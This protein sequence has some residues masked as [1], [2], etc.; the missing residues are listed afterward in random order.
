MGCT[1]AV[2]FAVW[3]QGKSLAES[4]EERKMRL[5]RE[6]SKDVDLQNPAVVND[7]ILNG[8]W[9]KGTR[10][11]AVYAYAD[12]CAFLGMPYTPLKIYREEKLPY[13]PLESRVDQLV[14][15]LSKTYAFFTR[16]RIE[17]GAALLNHFKGVLQR[18]PP[19]EASLRARRR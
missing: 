19:G 3:L 1:H 5:I 2:S 18:T 4:T 6:L 14:D 7:Y 13:V 8:S 16:D 12:Y 10:Q 11:L 9:S 15:G 17:R